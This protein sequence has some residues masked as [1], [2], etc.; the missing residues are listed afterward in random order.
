MKRGFNLPVEPPFTFRRSVVAFFNQP[1]APACGERFYTTS[2]DTSILAVKTI[3]F[4]FAVRQY[5]YART[6]RSAI[7]KTKRTVTRLFRGLFRVL[8]PPYASTPVL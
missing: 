4:K 7:Y 5:P 1:Y 2:S 6:M 8:N 3:S